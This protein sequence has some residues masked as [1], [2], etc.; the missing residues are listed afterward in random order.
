[1]AVDYSYLS[2][3][4]LSAIDAYFVLSLLSILT[5]SYIRPTVLSIE[6]RQLNSALP[7]PCRTHRAVV[8]RSQPVTAVQGLYGYDTCIILYLIPH[9]SFRCN[10]GYVRSLYAT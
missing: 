2:I 5:V 10:Y 9:S 4:L 6:D 1:M 3:Y 8:A 7:G